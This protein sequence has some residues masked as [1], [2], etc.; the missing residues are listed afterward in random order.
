[1]D[2]FADFPWNTLNITQRAPTAVTPKRIELAAQS[3]LIAAIVLGA[4]ISIG[5]NTLLIVGKIRLARWRL[6]SF[7]VLII[8]LLLINILST[9]LIDPWDIIAYSVLASEWPFSEAFCH[10]R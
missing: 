8:N 5:L 9:M 1:M 2:E 4:L 10:F 3:F 7:D 6:S